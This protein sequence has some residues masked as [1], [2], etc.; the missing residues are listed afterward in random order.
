MHLWL[1]F[2]T[3]QR[4]SFCSCVG[5]IYCIVRQTGGHFVP[6]PY[7]THR[8][9]RFFEP[10]VGIGYC[11]GGIFLLHYATCNSKAS[12]TACKAPSGIAECM[13]H[14]AEFGRHRSLYATVAFTASTVGSYL[15]HTI[16]LSMGTVSFAASTGRRFLFWSV[17]DPNPGSAAFLTP[18]SRIPNTMFWELF[19]CLCW[20]RYPGWI[21]IRIRDKYPGFAILLISVVYCM[22]LWAS[23]IVYRYTGGHCLL[24]LVNVSIVWISPSSI[25][26]SP[27]VPD[28]FSD[29]RFLGKLK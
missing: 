20:V 25:V 26:I 17:A 29:N 19:C 16:R 14:W 7:C 24:H 11:I 18:E 23:L 3:C 27:I 13:H 22:H 9:S 4:T 28:K 12:F 8:W 1:L 15:L 21:K 5:S 10:F 6:V 2:I